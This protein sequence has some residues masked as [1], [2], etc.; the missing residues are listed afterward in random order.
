MAS[1]RKR[2]ASPHWLAGRGR[3]KCATRPSAAPN[4]FL[5]NPFPPI[6]GV[7][8]ARVA[9]V[10]NGRRN[11]PFGP[12][13]STRRLHPCGLVPQRDMPHRR[14]RKQNG[15]GVKE[16]RL[17]QMGPTERGILLFPSTNTVPFS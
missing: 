17:P 13:G 12:G 16:V 6:F 4:P 1:H 2:D 3:E 15:R 8:P 10:I 14:G 7:P 9:M 5:L 11:K